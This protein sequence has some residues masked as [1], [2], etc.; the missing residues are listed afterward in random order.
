MSRL[1]RRLL[2]QLV[3]APPNRPAAVLGPDAVEVLPRALRL[4]EEWCRTFT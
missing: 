1:A 4:G 2:G 3:G